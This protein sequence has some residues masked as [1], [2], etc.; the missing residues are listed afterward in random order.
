MGSKASG[1]KV[2]AQRFMSDLWSFQGSLISFSRLSPHP[3]KFKKCYLF[4][5]LR[6]WFQGSLETESWQMPVVKEHQQIRCLWIWERASNDPMRQRANDLM[7]MRRR[8]AQ[9]L[10]HMVKSDCTV[11]TVCL[12]MATSI[13]TKYGEKHNSGSSPLHSGLRVEFLIFV[14]IFKLQFSLNFKGC[15]SDSN[16]SFCSSMCN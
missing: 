16:L 4:L 12:W 11:C 14:I 3:L 6:S 10:S 15:I 8:Q 1:L 13:S 2:W 7:N 5:S 9:N